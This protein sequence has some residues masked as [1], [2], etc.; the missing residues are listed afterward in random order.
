MGHGPCWPIA[1]LARGNKFVVVAIEYFTR[2]IEAKP[3][4]I[5]TLE[6][7]RKIFWQN[8]IYR[9]GVPRI[10]MVDDG[11]QFDSEKFKE[12]CKTIGTTV[13]FASVYHLES[14]GVVERANKIIFSAISIT[15]F[16]LHKGKWV[17]ELPKV[18][19]SHNTTTS[20]AM[21]LT[22]F[23]LLYGEEAMLPEEVKH[24]SLWVIKQAL[25]AD[26]EYSKE[27]IKGA[28]LE[29]IQNITKYQQQ[30]K[31]WRYSHIVRNHIQD[32]ELVPRRKLNAASAGKLQPKWEGPYTAKVARRP[33]SFYLTDGEG[34]TTTHT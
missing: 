31:K 10:L 30:T 8:I 11:K 5:I 7:I 15:L 2:W 25:A 4:A 20:K 24:Q 22:P 9:F 1:T 26:E 16:N 27:T 21:G 3:L 19:W 23:K 28:R 32:G 6:S 14:N 34:R 13:A 18:V 17:E 33:W 12:F 29:A